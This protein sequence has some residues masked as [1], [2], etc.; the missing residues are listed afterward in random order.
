MR[1]FFV[2][3]LVSVLTVGTLLAPATALAATGTGAASLHFSP[4]SGSYT[5]GST[6]TLTITENSSVPVA[7]VEADLTYP[8]NLLQCNGP[9][10][11][12]A[13]G[14]SYQNTC[15]GGALTL[16]VGVQGTT[17]SGPQTVGT[18]SFTVLAAG[19]AA[20]KVTGTSE[21]DDATTAN[22]F[23]TLLVPL[24]LLSPTTH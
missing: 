19:N 10:S 16:A 24:A 1:Q 13:F 22:V 7:A 11:L 20:L 14:T 8:A 9:A 6:I 5:V 15:A 18:V 23:V 12:G 17:V 3:T 21:I 2:K 4:S